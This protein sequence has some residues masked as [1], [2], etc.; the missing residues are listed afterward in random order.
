MDICKELTRE[1]YITLLWTTA[2]EALGIIITALILP[3]IGR[4]WVMASEM[5]VVTIFTGLLLVCT[6]KYASNISSAL[7]TYNIYIAISL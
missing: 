6:L 4:K 1:D 2:A 3:F 5:V 7:L